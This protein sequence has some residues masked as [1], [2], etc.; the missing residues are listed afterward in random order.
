MTK[1]IFNTKEQYI[2]F[3]HAWSNAARIS[4]P[5]TSCWL[6][7]AHHLMFNLLC[8]KPAERG[9]TPITRKT[10]LQNGHLINAGLYDAYCSLS[11]KISR[12]KEIVNGK[13]I[14]K[15]A[16]DSLVQFLAPFNHVVTIDLLAAIELPKIEPLYSNYGIGRKI[17]NKI[18]EGDFKPTDFSQIYAIL[19]EAA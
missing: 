12:A 8:G 1:S 17:A 4:D 9:F 7:G 3:R 11:A 5:E 14:P 16:A 6:Q 13:S 18:L 19:E 15:Y 2:S 10:K